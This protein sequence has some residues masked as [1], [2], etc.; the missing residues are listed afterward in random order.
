M[1][2][3]EP[4]V[5]PPADCVLCGRCCFSELPEYVRVFGVDLDRMD[6][7]AQGY[8][9]FI[10]NRCYMR[11][12]GGRCAALRSDPDTGRHTC[13]IY[14]MRPDVCRSLERGSGACRGEWSEKATR[15]AALLVELRRAREPG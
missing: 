3:P 11:M 12:E 10:G 2:A 6:E 5:F 7:R 8:T 1:T 14:E 4:E 15:P 13:R 9:T